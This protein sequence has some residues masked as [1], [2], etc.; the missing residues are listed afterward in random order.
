[1]LNIFFVI[2]F[3]VEEEG[4]NLELINL[5]GKTALHDAAQFTQPEVLTYLLGKGNSANAI[6]FKTSENF[7]ISFVK[8]P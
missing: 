7:R 1:M 8:Y 6:N 3:L 5:D 2:R 4:A